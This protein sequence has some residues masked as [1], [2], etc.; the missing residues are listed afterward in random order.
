MGA[1]LLVVGFALLGCVLVA[2]GYWGWNGQWT[3]V[4]LTLGAGFLGKIL[5]GLAELIL[6]PASLPVVYFGRRGKKYLSFLF[7]LLASLLTRA[8]YAAYCIAVLI[9]FPSVP[10]PPTWLAIM[11][12]IAVAVSPFAWASQRTQEDDHPA[13]LDAGAA[14]LGMVMA[15]TLLA[16]DVRLG[17][18]VLPI[19]GLF[20]LSA[21]AAVFWWITKGLPRERINYLISR[22]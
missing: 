2:L 13:N 20:V 10:G 4:L 7:S 19:L 9:Y 8:V 18:V 6:T 12:S 3:P 11:V 22:T 21:L 1:I 17:F 5:L 16:F 14:M 15:G